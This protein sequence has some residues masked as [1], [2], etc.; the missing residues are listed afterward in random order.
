MHLSNFVPMEEIKMKNHA[1]LIIRV[2]SLIIALAMMTAVLASCVEA[3][4]KGD[5]G[6]VGESGVPGQPGQPGKDGETPYV[7][8]NGNWWIGETDTG[9]RAEGVPGTD[10]VNGTDG[11]DGAD[12]EDGEDG[13]DGVTPKLRING[14]GYWEVSYDEGKSWES[15]GVKAYT[16]IYINDYGYWVIDGVITN[17]KAGTVETEKPES[18]PTAPSDTPS[19]TPAPTTPPVIE[20]EPEPEDPTKEGTLW[21]YENF[22]GYTLSA[23][24]SKAITALGWSYRQVSDATIATSNTAKFG[25]ADYNGSRMLSVTNYVSGTTAKDSIATIL[26]EYQMGFLHRFNYT[27]QYDVVYKDSSDEKRYFVMISEYNGSTHYNTGHFR[28]NGGLNHEVNIGGGSFNKYSNS[29]SVAAKLLGS[30]TTFKDLS[31]SVRYQVNWDTGNKIYIRVNTP[32]YPESGNWVLAAQYDASTKTADIKYMYDAG[33]AIGLKIGGGIN[34]YID[35]ILIWSGNGDEPADKSDPFLTTSSACHYMIDVGGGK[36]CA[37][38]GRTQSAIDGAWLLSDTPRFEGGTPS[39]EIYLCGQGIDPSQP[40][41]NEAKMQIISGTTAEMF[42]SYIAKL[43]SNGY[44]L[45]FSNSGDGNLFRSY[46]KGTQRIYTYFIAAIGET[47]VISESTSYSMSP[48]S[49]GYTYT[50]S[51]SDTT[52]FYQYELPLRKDDGVYTY[53]NGYVDRG[54]LYIIKLADNSVILVDGGEAS[55]WTDKR[56]GEL[57]DFLRQIT[58]TPDGGTL[59][60]SAWY[61]THAHGDHL[62]GFGMLLKKYHQN[63]DLERV[64]FNLPSYNSPNAELRE[65]NSQL[66]KI[67]GYIDQYCADDNVKF[68]KAHTGQKIQLANVTIDVMYTHEDLVDANTGL[69]EVGDDYNET[70]LVLKFTFDGKSFMILG[71]TNVKGSAILM[72]NWSESCLKVDVLQLAHHVLNDLTSLYKLIKASV[73]LVPQSLGRMN[74]NRPYMNDYYE[75]ALAYVN[76]DTVVIDDE[77][78]T[79]SKMSYL[80][81]EGTVGLSVV[82]GGVKKVFWRNIIS[83]EKRSDDTW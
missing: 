49:F 3:G 30:A 70:S 43:A 52:V 15:L 6:D 59:R 81:N 34:G 9:V 76:A 27:Y 72:E 67:L 57:W 65:A 5:K 75:T 23:D 33:A 79:N 19:E 74:S 71:D 50:P 37:L 7:G 10:G 32:G 17:V 8:E 45:E 28:A 53:G 16:D 48:E 20:P 22:E 69:T 35:N 77:S 18:K 21:F 42:N 82:N 26:T 4:P 61:L 58:S 31:V 1:N 44:S 36:L 78:R 63:I 73:I 64:I 83:Y 41:S 39:D 25:I 29:T 12:G 62:Q 40:I 51:A 11:T 55:Q 2:F 24:T 47:R 60:I 46:T 54:M 68:I 14:D 80:Q 13:K 56:L 38:C 66:K